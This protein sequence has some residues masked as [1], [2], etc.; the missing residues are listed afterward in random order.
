MGLLPKP[1]GAPGT[2]Y[3]PGTPPVPSPQLNPL[4]GAPSASHPGPTSSTPLFPPLPQPPALTDASTSSPANAAPGAVIYITS[5]G[6]IF[7]DTTPVPSDQFGD[8]LK[9]KKAANQDLKLFVHMDKNASQDDL[10][11]VMD[12]G[13]QAGFGVLPYIYTSGADSHPSAATTNAASASVPENAPTTNAAPAGSNAVATPSIPEAATN[14]APS[15]PVTNSIPDA[16]SPT[17]SPAQTQ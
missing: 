5:E 10:A 8:F 1:V 16:T 15:A 7:F 3:V 13:A 6:N 11:R 14:S 4:V 9:T 12:A 2:V 17:P